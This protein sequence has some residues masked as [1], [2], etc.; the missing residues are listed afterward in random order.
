[1]HHM[2]TQAPS[3]AAEEV[4]IADTADQEAVKTAEDAL[5]IDLKQHAR[6]SKNCC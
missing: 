2:A 3:L 4:P 6:V 1:M 5:H